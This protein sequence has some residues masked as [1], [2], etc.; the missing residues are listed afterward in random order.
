MATSR[1]GWP[2]GDRTELDIRTFVVPGT[3]VHLALRADVAPLLLEMALWWHRTVE[4][5][6]A[7]WCEGYSYR[8]VH[9]G[10]ALSNHASGT[11][12]DLNAP[13]H[14]TGRAGTL[15]RFRV[16][17]TRKAAS[18]G[19]RSGALHRRPDEMH[20]EVI[21][22]A[23]RAAELVAALGTPPPPAT[24]G[25]VLR[26]GA[27]GGAVPEAQRLLAAWCPYLGLV[28]DGDF[29]PATEAAVRE[30]QRRTGL[31]TD[32]VLGPRTLRVLGIS[33]LARA[34]AGG[35]DVA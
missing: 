6:H 12:V 17:V 25:P 29:G 30:L 26:R 1:N 20:V 28:V 24:P 22:P 19:L 15:G 7:D 9:G 2:A 13:L 16:A 3:D 31:A 10:D 23:Q 32:G 8:C 21:V 14:P 27:R 4:P 34:W 5:L 18:L 35:A 11:A 33:D